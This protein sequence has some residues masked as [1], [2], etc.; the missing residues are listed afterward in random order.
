[1]FGTYVGGTRHNKCGKY[2]YRINS[3]YS[4]ASDFQWRVNL[5]K[6]GVNLSEKLWEDPSLIHTLKPDQASTKRHLVKFT[7]HRKSD[8]SE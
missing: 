1:M 7:R 6:P 4:L 5:T 3:T 2:H 8:A